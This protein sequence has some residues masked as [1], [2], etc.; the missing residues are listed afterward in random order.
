MG[1]VVVRRNGLAGLERWITNA[2]CRLK[3]A[4]TL[5]AWQE[6]FMVP[7]VN[8]YRQYLQFNDPDCHVEAVTAKH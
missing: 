1:I 7:Y 8:C 6:V 3:T 5:L 2:K 4:V